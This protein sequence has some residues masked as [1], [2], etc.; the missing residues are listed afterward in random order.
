MSKITWADK[1]TLDAQP[2]VARI[3]KVIDDDM[4]EI[5]SVVNDNDDIV[6]DLSNLTTP[7]NSSIV[8]A[9]NSIGK[10]LW[11]GSFTSGDITVNGLSDY[12]VIIVVLDRGTGVYCI[13]SKNYG[14]GGVGDYASYSIHT[15]SYRFENPSPNVL[16]ITA[17]AKGGSDG[18]SQ[19]TVKAIYGLF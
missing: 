5:K 9:L 7:D 1:V 3:N 18:T 4:N 17:N 11:E 15:Y 16:E 6:G 19:A 13:G 2:D 8:G 10:K 12:T 14:L